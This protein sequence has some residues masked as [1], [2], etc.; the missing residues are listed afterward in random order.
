MMKAGKM[1]TM[2]TVTTM[3]HTVVLE[4]VPHYYVGYRPIGTQALQHIVVQ[5]ANMTTLCMQR[6]RGLLDWFAEQ[7][8]CAS[9][10]WIV[11]SLVLVISPVVF[12]IKRKT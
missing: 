9:Y 5:Q 12:R 1:M 3:P 8:C 11:L 10:C 4:Q 6:R 7:F 2:R